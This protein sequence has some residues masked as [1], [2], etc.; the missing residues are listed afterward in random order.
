MDVPPH[1]HHHPH[2]QQNQ[3][4]HDDGDD[5]DSGTGGNTKQHS[6]NRPPPRRVAYPMDYHTNP[7]SPLPTQITPCY[8][9]NAYMIYPIDALPDKPY[10]V[11]KLGDDLGVYLFSNGASAKSRRLDAVEPATAGEIPVYSSANELG[12]ASWLRADADGL[13]VDRHVRATDFVLCGRGGGGGD[14]D[15][16]EEISVS[17]IPEQLRWLAEKT[18]E[19]ERTIAELKAR[20]ETAERRI[21]ALEEERAAKDESPDRVALPCGWAFEP[22]DGSA[23]MMTH[24]GEAC[25]VFAPPSVVVVV[26]GGVQVATDSDPTREARD[27]EPAPPTP[28][29][30]S[31]QPTQATP[32]FEPTQATHSTEPNRATP[33]VEPTQATPSADPAQRVTAV[34]HPIA[35]QSLPDNETSR[36]GSDV[37]HAGAGLPTLPPSTATATATIATAVPAASQ[38]NATPPQPT[39]DPS[40]SA[41]VASKGKP[42]AA[43]VRKTRSRGK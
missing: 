30:G 18:A 19:G 43:A 11:L 1:H 26:E 41:D 17:A 24:G 35:S 7:L 32:S 37:G 16:A 9:A 2:H 34:A 36:A 13:V 8:G 38:T 22:G 42:A 39:G 20:C 31:T 3:H 10:R 27:I 29:V 4:H 33:S 40:H 6:C 25:T 5:D 21:T 12:G 23:L 14:G 28:S 15:G